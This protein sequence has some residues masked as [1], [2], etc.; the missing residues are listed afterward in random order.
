MNKINWPDKTY[1]QAI[2]DEIFTEEFYNEA[3][4]F[5]NIYD[6]ELFLE[7]GK[8]DTII[9]NYK[10]VSFDFNNFNVVNLV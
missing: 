10:L 8:L 3:D 5:G 1:H 6:M 4:Q 2:K 9:N 7:D